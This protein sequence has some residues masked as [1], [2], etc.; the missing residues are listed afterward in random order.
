VGNV[1][2]GLLL[3]APMTVYEL[4]K[5]FEAGI[6]L[7][8]SASLGSIRTAVLSV[9]AKGLVSVNESVENGRTKKTYSITRE[10]RAAFSEWML[11]PITS[12]D[13]ETAALAKLYFLGLM[14]SPDRTTA[15]E[16][17]LARISADEAELERTASELDAMRLPPEYAEIFRYQRH[18][19][20]YGIEA[21]R[22]GREFFDAVLR[23]ETP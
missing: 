21:H 22:R 23:R 12:S 4:N 6:S 17:I 19:L 11:A 9:L 2:L 13:V 20:E 7:F 14:P 15:L 5:Q 10:G 3:L 1:I 8:Y 16:G 18:T